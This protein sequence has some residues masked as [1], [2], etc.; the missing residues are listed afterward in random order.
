MEFLKSTKPVVWLDSE[1][2]CKNTGGILSAKKI[3]AGEQEF[4]T[5]GGKCILYAPKA[6]VL[7]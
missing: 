7:E 6:Q 5:T 4:N 1:N 3:L 2:D